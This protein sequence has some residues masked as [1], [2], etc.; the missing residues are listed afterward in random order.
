VPEKKAEHSNKAAIKSN[1][2]K[3][4]AS[5]FKPSAMAIP[6]VSVEVS[7]AKCIVHSIYAVFLPAVPYISV[8]L[9]LM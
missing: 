6:A 3:C 7:I 8:R 2:M 1:A 9:I 5:I 4:S